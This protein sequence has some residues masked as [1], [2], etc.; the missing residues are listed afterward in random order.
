MGFL[1]DGEWITEESLSAEGGS[2][3][4]P[5]TV[6]RDWVRDEPGARFAPEAGRYHL[7]VSYACPWAHRALLIRALKGLEEVIPVSVAHPF[8]GEGG[9]SFEP[10]EGVEPDP[11]HGA[12]YLREVYLAA[13][14]NFSGRVTVPVLWDRKEETIVNNESREILRMLDEA[15]ADLAT[16]AVDLDPAALHDRIEEVIDA[17]YEPIN[18]GVYRCGFAGDQGSYER[19]FGELFEALDHW[20]EVLGASRYLCGEQL[21]EADICMFTTLVRFDPVYYVHFKCNGRHIYEY[22]NLSGYLRELYQLPG[23]AETVHLDHIKGHYYTSH[24]SVNPRR[25]VPVGPLDL[26]LRRPPRPRAPAGRAARRA[27]HR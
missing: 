22:P 8:M 19:A 9:W 11:I 3:E 7:Y 16:R 10:G 24:E 12:E 23:V 13:D 27:P 2:F 15:F 14:P 6:F 17:I 21:T 26:D 4:R 18:N 25:F 1:K 5:D 20:D